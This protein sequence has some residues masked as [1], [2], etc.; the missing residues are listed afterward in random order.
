MEKPERN[1]AVDALLRR[2]FST[3]GES[4]TGVACLDPEIVAAWADGSLAR[5]D[6]AIAEAHASDCGRCRALLAT[7]VQTEPEPRQERRWHGK[8]G[9]RWLVPFAASA[10]AVA[11]WF[12]LPE[13]TIPQLKEQER[14]ERSKLTPPSEPAAAAD[15]RAGASTSSLERRQPID[16]NRQRRAAP[17]SPPSASQ[18]APL[19]DRDNAAGAASA[20]PDTRPQRR[21]AGE[22]DALQKRE[23]SSGRVSARADKAVPS[24]PAAAP[25]AGGA[26]TLAER[27][28]VTGESP[29][30]GGSVIDSLN[31][32]ARWRLGGRR[33]VERSTDGGSTWQRLTTD[34]DVELIAAHSPTPLVCWF[35]GRSGTVLLTDDGRAVR[36]VPFPENVDL[37]GVR[38]TDAQTAVVTAT[39][40]R[41]F[42]TSDRGTTWMLDPR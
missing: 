27:V 24:A 16:P 42:R 18:D 17:K 39:D 8:I 28:T 37:T 41:T 21:E 14:V 29:I 5:E 7:V 35:V 33:F 30:V 20:A 12:A 25:L 10:L 11:V 22:A 23:N 26:A 3:T 40:G 19:L 34:G 36:R 4:A 31:G 9:L 38:A 32:V 1:T 6:R 15:A 13:R 2:S